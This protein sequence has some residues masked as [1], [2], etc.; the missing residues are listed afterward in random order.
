MQSY[1][2]QVETAAL[3]LL[4][5]L[6]KRVDDIEKVLTNL[7]GERMPSR[8]F[9]ACTERVKASPGH[10]NVSV[11][12]LHLATADQLEQAISTLR[13]IAQ[14]IQ[15]NVP[16]IEDGNNFGVEVQKCVFV[17]VKEAIAALEK[18]WESIAEYHNQRTSIVEKVQEKVAKEKCT[19]RTV[20]ASK[21]GKDGDE[22][23]SVESTVEKETA[24]SST[25]LPDCLG[26]LSALDM[27]WYFIYVRTLESIRDQ[28]VVVY[29]VI[30]KNKEKVQM[31]RGEKNRGGYSM[32]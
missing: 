25:A 4:E 29:D 10:Q 20:T 18:H 1:S 32:Y 22:D 27:K 7:A 31:P 19:T 17:H 28:Y 30:E 6:P 13:M 12:A 3:A 11:T 2:K 8:V 14:W 23:K 15:L 9:A 21:G 24:T 5:S 26:H 16:K